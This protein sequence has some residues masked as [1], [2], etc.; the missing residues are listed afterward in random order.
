MLCDTFHSLLFLQEVS[1]FL[2]LVQ[3]TDSEGGSST[4]YYSPF[5]SEAKL[6][7]LNWLCVFLFLL[8]F[9]EPRLKDLNARTP[10]FFI[11]SEMKR[12]WEK[13]QLFCIVKVNYKRV[14]DPAFKDDAIPRS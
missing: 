12:A 4:N 1:S 7:P 6:W 2:V 5:Q 10:A 9:W 8:H 3:P 13:S 11:R 14:H